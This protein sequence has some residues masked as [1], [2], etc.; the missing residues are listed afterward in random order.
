MN[1]AQQDAIV[2]M[3]ESKKVA[4]AFLQNFDRSFYFVLD[5]VD[6]KLKV[7]LHSKDSQQDIMTIADVAH[8]LQCD[9]AAVRR[10]TGSRAQHRSHHPLPFFKIGGKLLRFR[11]SDV[12][13]WIDTMAS[14]PNGKNNSGALSLV[15]GKIKKDHK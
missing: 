5:E 4:K 10:L 12:L 3:F 14:S 7:A 13:A 1:K 9:R 11:R 6:G 15:K 2:R 8:L